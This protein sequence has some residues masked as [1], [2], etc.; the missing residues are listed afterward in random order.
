[1]SWQTDTLTGHN[2]LKSKKKQKLICNCFLSNRRQIYFQSGNSLPLLSQGEYVTTVQEKSH[3]QSLNSHLDRL[4]LRLELRP[5]LY[6]DWG[7]NDGARHPTGPA[8]G[9]L[10]ADK[11]V[12]D[13][14][15][16]AEQ[17]Q[18]EDDLQWFS[19]SG[20]HDELS[21]ASVQGFS[22]WGWSRVRKY[23]S[24]SLKPKILY[25]L[26]HVTQT[27]SKFSKQKFEKQNQQVFLDSYFKWLKEKLF[28]FLIS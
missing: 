18:V 25:L 22:G 15:V 3:K 11:H 24:D 16:L 6:G 28:D 8:Q 13:V 21:D 7:S 2:V 19:I 17:W 14:L 4:N 23:I 26:M 20:H 9:L 27:S 10:G 1:M 5:L 12:R